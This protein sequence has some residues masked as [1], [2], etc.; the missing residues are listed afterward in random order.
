MDENEF[1]W[2]DSWALL[3][4]FAMAANMNKSDTSKE[5]PA[6]LQ[7]RAPE[8]MHFEKTDWNIVNIDKFTI[9]QL[10]AAAMNKKEAEKLRLDML[11][12]A[13]REENDQEGDV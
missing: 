1:D 7:L 4:L 6:M 8:T 3:T 5:E 13:T 11:R 10:R 9:E 12:D 2:I